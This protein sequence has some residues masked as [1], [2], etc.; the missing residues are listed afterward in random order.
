MRAYAGCPIS[1]E[2]IVNPRYVW[3]NGK[4]KLTEW[5]D[6]SGN[7]APSATYGSEVEDLMQKL[8]T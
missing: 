3:V 2:L 1:G 7:W 6:L 4:F 8:I 5:S